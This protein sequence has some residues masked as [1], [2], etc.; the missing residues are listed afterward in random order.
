MRVNIMPEAR[1]VNDGSEGKGLRIWQI[2][3]LVKRIGKKILDCF[4][5]LI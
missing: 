4:H 1:R 2:I 5:E 3:C